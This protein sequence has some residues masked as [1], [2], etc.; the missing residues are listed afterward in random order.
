VR[1]P[2]R[3]ERQRHKDHEQRVNHRLKQ[4]SFLR[5]AILLYQ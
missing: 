4:D 3:A 2:H 1:A 5:I